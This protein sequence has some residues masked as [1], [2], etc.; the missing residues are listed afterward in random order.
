MRERSR[1][2]RHGN[3]GGDRHI[4]R[5]ATEI[6]KWMML[7]GRSQRSLKSWAPLVAAAQAVS[8]YRV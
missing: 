5:G 4:Y 7:L 2:R 8:S 6:V 1:G 3:R